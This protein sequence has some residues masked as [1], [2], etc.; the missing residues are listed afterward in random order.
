MKRCPECSSKK[1]YQ[2]ADGRLKCITCGK[3]YR[4]A[5]A[6]SASRLPDRTKHRLL[7]WFVLG[8]PVYR[9]RFRGVASATPT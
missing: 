4:L 7:E 9:Q 6:W 1:A 5:S 2:L 3:R 8:V